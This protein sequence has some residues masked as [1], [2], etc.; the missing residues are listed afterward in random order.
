M[1]TARVGTG[2]PPVQAEQSSAAAG[3]HKQLR[4]RDKR[5][6]IRVV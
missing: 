1:S 3:D 4:V 2:A 6:M 5:S